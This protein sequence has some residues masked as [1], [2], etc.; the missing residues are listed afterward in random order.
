MTS[1][2]QSPGA[3]PRRSRGG[4]HDIKRRPRTA[5][6][7]HDQRCSSEENSSGH[8]EMDVFTQLAREAAEKGLAMP[9]YTFAK[10]S[11]GS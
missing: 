6:E 9:A 10:R 4:T 7:H 1:A 2:A 8:Q 3:A 5:A 11:K